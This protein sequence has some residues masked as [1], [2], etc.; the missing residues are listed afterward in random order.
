MRGGQAQPLNAISLRANAM[1][2]LKML[3]REAVVALSSDYERGDRLTE[4]VAQTFDRLT[5]LLGGEA[6]PVRALSHFSEDSAVRIM[7]IHKCKGLEFDTVVILGVEQQTFWGDRDE[8][9]SAFFVGISRAKS[10]LYL[11][12]AD[13]RQRPTEA[14]N[15]WDIVRRPHDEYIGHATSSVG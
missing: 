5:E 3:G 2:F 13:Q 10:R 9:R 6:D 11:T 8:Q 15:R 12:V 7:T 14:Q 4:V 1:T